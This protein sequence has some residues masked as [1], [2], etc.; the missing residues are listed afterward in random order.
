MSALAIPG[1]G[2]LSCVYGFICRRDPQKRLQHQFRGFQMVPEIYFIALQSCNINF[3]QAAAQLLSGHKPQKHRNNSLKFWEWT[4][5]LCS[6]LTILLLIF[7]LIRKFFLFDLKIYIILK[8][9]WNCFF[10]W[11]KQKLSRHWSNLFS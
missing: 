10:G 4:E 8:T 2:E 6:L 9:K 7:E 11:Q 5:L 3:V 1:S